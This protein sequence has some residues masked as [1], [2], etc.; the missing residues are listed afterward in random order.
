M[1]AKILPRV[2]IIRKASRLLTWGDDV[3]QGFR[4][5]H[6]ETMMLEVRNDTPAER[7]EQLRHGNR[8]FFNRAGTRRIASQLRKFSP[9]L[10]LVLNFAGLPSSA[11]E[12]IR[13]ALGSNVP[14]V[15]WLCDRI[16]RLPPGN[17][18]SMDG[19]Y[20][21]DSICSRP[22]REAY[23]G[24]QAQLGYLPLAA[25]PRRYPAKQLAMAQRKPRVV[26]AGNCT[27]ER[28][29]AFNEFRNLGGEIDLHGPNSKSD[30]FGGRKLSSARLADLYQ[31]YMACFNLLQVQNTTLGLNLRAFE[32]PCAGG[33]A[34]YPDVPDLEKCFVPD[35]EVISYSSIPDLKQK[36][37][38]IL[39]DPDEAEAITRAGHARVI[40]EHTFC[41][42]AKQI[43]AEYL[44]V[45]S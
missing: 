20:Y 25:C 24:T 36:L 12:Q 44:P 17:S 22:L 34:T 42:R 38:R 30:W 32:I 9:D 41:H 23:V 13:C 33:L 16:E 26:F 10:V 4:Q 19:V 7:W 15:G 37:D 27:P 8:H 1:N 14:V 18:P 31:D 21:F 6:A 3:A 28:M 43:M 5:A 29:A 11:D 35:R 45:A 40:A 2:A 39:R